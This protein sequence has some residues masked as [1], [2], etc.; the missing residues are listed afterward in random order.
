MYGG[1]PKKNIIGGK[2]IGFGAAG[3]VKMY[4]S[5]N[6]P[7]AA[8]LHEG[9]PPWEPRAWKYLDTGKRPRPKV[10]KPAVGQPKWLEMAVN[11]IGRD[12]RRMIAR[13]LKVA[14]F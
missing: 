6:T 2:S 14:G 7:Y 11:S 4:V 5:Y 9:V 8:R 1:P 3:L 10:E 12:L 13:E